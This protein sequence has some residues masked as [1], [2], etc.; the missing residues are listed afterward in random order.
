MS[1]LVKKVH[2]IDRTLREINSTH[3]PCSTEGLSLPQAHHT[4]EPTPIPSTKKTTITQTKLPFLST[5]SLPAISNPYKPTTPPSSSKV[6]IQTKINKNFPT[7]E[8]W[9]GSKLC[10]L[11]KHEFRIWIQNINGFDV[12]HNFSIF[13]EHFEYIKKYDISY[14]ALTEARLNPYSAYVSESI[15]SAFQNVYPGSSSILSNQYINNEDICQYGGVFSGVTQRL[16]HRVAGMGKDSL[17]RFNWIDFYGTDSFLRIYTVYRV[18]PGCDPTSGDDTCWTHQRTALL[19]KNCDTDPRTQVVKD[20]VQKLK[21]DIRL[22]RKILVCGDI[23]ENVTLLKGFNKAMLDLG[24]QNLVSQFLP[25]HDPIRSHNRGHSIIDG[26]WSSP[27][28][29]RSVIRCGLAPFHHVF[30]SD[31]RGMFVDLD[32]DHFLDTSS[33]PL[34]APAYRR[35]KFTIPKRVEAYSKKA[36]SLWQLQN[37]DLRIQQLE[38]KLPQL[39]HDDRRFLLNKIDSEI[40]ILMRSSEKKCCKVGRHCTASFSKEFKKALRQFRQCR[41][42]L[43]R[44]LMQ[45]GDGV[46]R[47]ETIKQAAL[48]KRQAKRHLKHCSKN[49]KPLRDQMLDDLATDTIQMHPNRGSK[50]KSVI[51]QLKNCEKSRDDSTKVRFATKGPRSDAI[52]YVLIPDVQEYSAQERNDPNFSI[53]DIERIWTRTQT[54]NG[55]DISAWKRIDDIETVTTLISQILMK[56][57]GQSTGT[58]FANIY[59]KQ[60][61]SDPN[62]QKLLLDGQ[63]CYDD[64]LPPAANELLQSFVQK[65]N[66][67]EI[68]LIPTWKEF[69]TFISKS[70]EKTSSSPSG[71]HYGHYKSLLHSA[72]T[73]LKGIYKL[74]SL[75]LQYGIVLDRWKKT[76]TTV[77]CKDD[78]TPY[79]HRL[80]PLH[81]VESELQFFSK[82]QWSYKLIHQAEH[83]KNISPSQYGGRKNKQAQSSVINTI[84]QFDIHRQIRKPYT[85]NDDDLRANY[86]RELAHYSVAETRCHGLSESAGQ[87][88]IN[89]TSQQQFHIKT[90]NGVS[91]SYYSF[92]NEHP[93]WGL[94]QGISWAGSCWQFTATS[95]ENCLKQTCCG[96]FLSNPLNTIRISPFIKF[97]IDDTNKICNRTIHL[98]SLLAQTSHNMQKH[99]DLVVATGGT[100]ALDKCRFYFI[101]FSFDENHEAY[102]LSIDDNPGELEIFDNSTGQQIRIQR[103]ENTDA[104]RTLGCYISPSNTQHKQFQVLEVYMSQWKNQMQHSSLSPLLVLKAYETILKPQLVYRLAT[105]SFTYEQCEELVKIIRPTILHAH[106]THQSFPKSIL[107][108][109]SLYAGFNFTHIYDLQGYE[110]LKFFTYHLRQMDDNGM[111][112]LISLQYTQLSLGVSSMFMNLPYDKY[113]FLTTETWNTNLWEYLSRNELSIDLQQ[114][115]PIPK[116]REGDQFIMDILCNQFQQDDLIKINKIRISLQLLFLSDM[117]DVR[118]RHIL[119]DIK[120]AISYRASSILFPRQ[121]FSPTWLKLWKS[122]CNVLNKYVSTNSLQQWHTMHFDWITKLSACKQFLKIRN[123]NYKYDSSISLYRECTVP[124]PSSINYDTP[125]DIYATKKGYNIISTFFSSPSQVL[126]STLQTYNRFHLFGQFERENEDHIVAAIKTNKAKMCSDGSVLKRYGS[127]AYGLAP[128]KS[129]KFIFSQHAPVHGDLDQITSTRC[130]LMGLLACIEYLRY[131][132]DKYTFDR[133]YFILITADNEVAIKAPKKFYLSTKYTFSPDMDII[134]HIKHLLKTTPFHI[135]FQHVRGHQD[136]SKPFHS[137][138]ILAKLNIHADK[139]AGDYFTQPLLAPQYSLDYDFLYGSCVSI[140][141]PHSRIASS[142]F[143]NIKRHRTGHLAEKQ[144]SKALGISLNHLHLLDWE[145]FQTIHRRQPKALQ[146]FVTKSIYH[147]LP[148][149]YR[150]HKWKIAQ[151]PTCPI[152]HQTPETPDHLFQC[153][154]SSSQCFRR[155]QLQNLRSEL[156]Q[157]DTNPFLIRHIMRILLQWTNGF[158]VNCLPYDSTHPEN[159]EAVCAINDQIKLGVNNFLRGCVTWRLGTVQLLHYQSKRN[160]RSN[161]TT[162]SRKLIQCLFQISHEIWKNRCNLLAELN[163]DTYEA[164]TRQKCKSLFIQLSSNPTL[165]PVK[166]RYLLDRQD[167]FAMTSSL[168]A[169]TSW[170]TRINLGLERAKSGQLTSTSDIRNWFQPKHNLSSQEC[171]PSICEEM[172]DE[173]EIV[174]FQYARTVPHL[175]Y[176]PYQSAIQTNS[177]TQFSNAFDNLPF[178]YHRDL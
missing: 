134:L 19:S 25:Q 69:T 116:Q 82:I 125:C 10:S 137:L 62:F 83:N 97:F 22:N 175:P 144:L 76:I 93:V 166:Y 107:E 39:N 115:I 118:G 103:V 111:A 85:F 163:N 102:I 61:L 67:K 46:T 113:A 54:K 168:R 141:D 123:T 44:L 75:S 43:A 140:K 178:P 162:W 165:L 92:S 148:T 14:F 126:Q 72:P 151:H 143:K 30:D 68:P 142:F 161:G 100:L 18:N 59:W 173:E 95:I 26:I 48:E 66:I 106:R 15:E 89:I 108:T 136:R 55:K 29:I 51:K 38:D 4:N 164:Q 155:K 81:I 37:M 45:L 77:I 119:P 73:I 9:I 20:L 84:L 60:K 96:A 31:H 120:N 36:L 147:H 121:T 21:D 159:N 3:V 128:P 146:S 13:M 8:Q 24:L 169:L 133:K 114:T 1:S 172:S 160:F 63:F 98:P 150:Q 132:S 130:E 177:M 170:L 101:D 57:F 78:N 94:G 7:D 131:I 129:D 71:R 70:K 79:I 41:T 80:R 117:V 17:G 105:T 174:E 153:T 88:L 6:S 35:L 33:T 139:L 50:K 138:S 157:L 74:L 149:L 122:A 154:A 52:S 86:D 176:V 27:T 112:I 42:H 28:I 56:H 109:S 99:F 171:I 152:C 124:I 5:T 156:I 104:R 127:F 65:P 91:S 49:S 90:K 53:F 167:H 64:S 135:R 23:N 11:T 58:P 12:S 87:M 2:S 32:L 34:L 47:H 40:D 16:T 110:K 158:P 145:N